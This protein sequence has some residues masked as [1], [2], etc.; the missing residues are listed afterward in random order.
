MNSAPSIKAI[1]GHNCPPVNLNQHICANVS[2]LAAKMNS[3]KAYTNRWTGPKPAGQRL[4]RWKRI[5]LHDKLKTMIQAP[6][7]PY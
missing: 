2:F 3:G 7:E 5:E 6:Y 1:I 4:A